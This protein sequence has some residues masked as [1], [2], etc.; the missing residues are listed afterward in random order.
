MLTQQCRA[1]ILGKARYALFDTEMHTR[2]LLQLVDLRRAIERQEFQI[3]YQP[4]CRRAGRIVGFEALVLAAPQ[5][6][7]VSPAEF[8]PLAEE[9]GLIIPRA[10]GARPAT[11]CGH[12]RCSF[13]ES[14]L[15]IQCEPV[16]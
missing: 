9:T 15:L 8:I 14:T 7:L 13:P 12:G 6:G 10:V 1:K 5:R 3:Y 11:R 4:V 2:A 16:C